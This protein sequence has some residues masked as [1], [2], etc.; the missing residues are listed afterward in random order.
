MVLNHWRMMLRCS[1]VEFLKRHRPDRHYLPMQLPVDFELRSC[2]QFKGERRSFPSQR[3]R[4]TEYMPL[5]RGRG[6]GF[7]L[8]R[9]YTRPEF[10]QL[11]GAAPPFTLHQGR[12]ARKLALARSTARVVEDEMCAHFEAALSPTEV[13]PERSRGPAVDRRGLLLATPALFHIGPVYDY[14]FET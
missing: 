14:D 1:S 10:A 7:V 3:G 9:A 12:T 13:P 6:F 4:K 11:R 8:I 2:R 5:R